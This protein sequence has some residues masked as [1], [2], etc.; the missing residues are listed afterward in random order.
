MLSSHQLHI[1]L[2]FLFCLP[3]KDEKTCTSS[4]IIYLIAGAGNKQFIFPERILLIAILVRGPYGSISILLIAILTYYHTVSS[5]VKCII[6]S[7]DSSRYFMPK[8]R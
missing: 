1:R 3:Y 7:S 6:F 4:F 5:G 2:I 8:W